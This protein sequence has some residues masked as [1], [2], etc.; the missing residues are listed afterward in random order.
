MPQL[1]ALNTFI[2]QTRAVYAETL[3]EATRWSRIGALLPALLRDSDMI[4]KAE[5]WPA[6][7]GTNHDYFNLLFYE[8]PAYGFVVNGM[9][10]VAGLRAIQ[11]DHAPTWTA[12]G[13]VSGSEEIVHF[14]RTGP[15]GRL[16]ETG[17]F[18]V[19]AGFS[20]VVPPD[21][22]HSEN[23][24]P[25]PTAMLIVRSARIGDFLQNM[26]DPETGA[27]IRRKGPRQVPYA[28]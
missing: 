22:V 25:E 8:D 5:K 1:P 24:G 14:R 17:R 20:E 15:D 26:Y 11:H 27:L 12:F 7:P 19:G 2:E 21:L 10:M 3:D 16:T 13:V 28:L 6:D 9:T 23:V 18:Q 4:R